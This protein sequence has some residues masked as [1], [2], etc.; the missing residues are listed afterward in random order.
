ME[1]VL[2]IVLL[3]L[4]FVALIK[5]ADIFVDGSSSLAAIFKVPSVIIGLTIVA[6]GTSAPEL[7]V[8]TSAALK[9]SNEIALSNVVGSNLF[10]LLMVL[11]VCALIKPVPIDKVICRRDFPFSIIT[12]LLLFVA[13]GVGMIGRVDFGTVKM[14]DNVATVSRPIG[15]VALLVFIGYIAM[16]VI[17]AKKNKAEG[18][19]V[20]TM[21]P[22]K[23][24]LFILF[25]VA[26][27]IA[28]GQFV[29]NSAKYI[30]A[31]FG[32]SETLIGLT[33]VAVGTSLPELVTSVVA[34]RKGENG[35]AVGNVV[36]S[37]IFNLLMILGVSA[38]LHPIPVNFASM[39]DFAILIIASVMV[40]IFSL[41]KHINRGE[42]I[43]MILM[44]VA[45]VVFAALR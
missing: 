20:K 19:P 29:V 1:M 34:A 18:E 17:S 12:T 35:L 25:G 13:L 28:G 39:V 42:G 23:S 32:M 11:G 26:L 40:Y 31:A 7:A 37:N 24:V 33:I 44:Y 36:G 27:I 30:A 6:L 8:S 2:Q 15:I 3:I 9:G 43:V 45:T 21:S 4:G 14:T 22:L 16:L 10:N 5:G 38:A 41:T